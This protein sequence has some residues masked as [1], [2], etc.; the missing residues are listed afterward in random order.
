LDAVCVKFFYMLEV[1]E[2]G[3][4]A[5]TRHRWLPSTPIDGKGKVEDAYGDPPRPKFMMKANFKM[6]MVI[7]VDGH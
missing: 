7:C 1:D 2:V 6:S 3:V 4:V 5:V